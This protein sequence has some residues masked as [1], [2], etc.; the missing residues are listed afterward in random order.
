MIY[1]RFRNPYRNWDELDR[2]QREINS[3]FNNFVTPPFNGQEYPPIN[4][5]TGEAGAILTA[6]VPGMDAK[7][8]DISVVGDTLTLTGSRDQDKFDEGTEY[9]RQER[10][11]GKFVRTVQLPFAVNGNKV[12]ARLVNGV[13]S[14]KLPRAESDKPKKITVKSVS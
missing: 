9:H 5:W 13:L 7:Q 1:R 10:T 3:V 6:E 11:F 4:V 2:V 8:I 14:I 12:E